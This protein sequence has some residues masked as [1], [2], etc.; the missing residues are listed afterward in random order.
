VFKSFCA[1][2][3]ALSLVALPS[4][5]LA[6]TTV[7]SSRAAWVTQAG[8]V[9]SRNMNSNSFTGVNDSNEYRSYISYA[10]PASTSAFTSAVIRVN[11]E[12]VSAGP[13]DLTVYDVSSD[14]ATA[15]GTDLYADFGSGTVFGT[16]TGLNTSG[17][18]V[19]ITLNADGLSAVNAARGGEISFGFVSS[20]NNSSID[21][22]FGLS[23]DITPRQLIL[24]TPATIP[25]LSEWA[26]ILFGL[27]LA[28]GAA[29]YIQ[30]RQTTV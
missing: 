13:N 16:I 7:N 14:I 21:G 30:R 24:T 17:A 23:T 8:A 29:L 6:Q 25:T 26:M 11:V 5:A 4:A 12:G 1:L 22:V 28:G 3:G 10:I 15:M 18:T 19:D 27:S 2:V 9:A 20:P